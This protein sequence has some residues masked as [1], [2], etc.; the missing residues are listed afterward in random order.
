MASAT[1]NVSVSIDKLAP[2]E[3]SLCIPFVFGNITWKRVKETIEDVGLGEVERVD[4][5]RG[6]TITTKDGRTF[7]GAQAY[8]H[9]KKWGTNEEARSARELVLRGEMFELTYEEPWFW[10][11]GMSHAKKPDRRTRKKTTQK[12]KTRPSLRVRTPAT[13]APLRTETTVHDLKQCVDD[14][15]RELEELRAFKE[16][17]TTGGAITPYYA[18]TTPTGTPPFTP[19][20]LTRQTGAD[21]CPG[22]PFR[23][24]RPDN[25]G[26]G[27]VS[28]GS[29][30]HLADEAEEELSGGAAAC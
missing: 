2:S 6:K 23:G 15:R 25:V 5:V 17:T 14:M 11:I 1:G 21:E 9:F 19:P 3:P 13:P 18:P 20:Y 12:S 27:C 29:P 8:I 22:A 28:G 30:R 24:G 4:M 16:R 10:K 26:T 7:K